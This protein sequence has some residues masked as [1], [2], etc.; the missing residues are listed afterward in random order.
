MNKIFSI[1]CILFSTVSFSQEC[2]KL[3]NGTFLLID[4][5]VNYEGK[6]TRE[7][8][9]QT[10][11]NQKT[12]H[13]TKGSIEWIDDCTYVM[14]YLETN[15]PMSKPFIGKKLTTNVIKIDGDKVYFKCW[16]EGIDFVAEGQMQI[17]N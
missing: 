1:I 8:S 14:T 9:L 17:I 15:S 13:F 10:E 6:I 7:D 2:E 11:I 4:E 5:R 12:G 16:M 3:R